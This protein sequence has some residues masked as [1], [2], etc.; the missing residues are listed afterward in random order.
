MS[1][2]A[3]D[4][5]V[6]HLLELLEPLGGVTAR[7]LFGGHG[8]FREGS[9]LALIYEKTFFVR[10]DDETR[11]LHEARGLKP[12]VYVAKGGKKMQMPYFEVPVEAFDDAEEMTRWAGPAARVAAA[13]AAAKKP[14]VA[15]KKPKAAAK[16]GGVK[17]AAAKKAAAPA[18]K[19][20][21]K[22]RTKNLASAAK[23]R[24]TRKVRPSAKKR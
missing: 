5:Q 12:F 20:A 22:K 13:V 4:P 2:L 10:V 18:K 15:A 16:K 14:K 17:Q 8:F 11:G 1:P 9:M 3:A 24:S 19:A 6:V 7:A 21:V 23:A